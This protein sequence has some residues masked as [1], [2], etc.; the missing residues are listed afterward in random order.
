VEKAEHYKIRVGLMGFERSA[1]MPRCDTPN[2]SALEISQVLREMLGL[3][4]RPNGRAMYE[5]Q[6]FPRRGDNSSSCFPKPDAVASK[7]IPSVPQSWAATRDEEEF[8]L[9]YYDEAQ[10]WEPGVQQAGAAGANRPG[11]TVLVLAAL[12]LHVPSFHFKPSTRHNGYVPQPVS[13]Q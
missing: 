9:R 7:M 4:M 12:G 2:A 8:N 6:N 1:G 11:A 10:P 5:L 3:I 13:D